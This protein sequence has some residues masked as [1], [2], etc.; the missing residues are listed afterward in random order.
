MLYINSLSTRD[1]AF[2]L[3]PHPSPRRG[4]FIEKAV[5]GEGGKKAR[6]DD[7]PPIFSSHY[8]RVLF[9]LEIPVEA[10]TGN[11]EP[12]LKSPSPASLSYLILV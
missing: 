4:N 3:I 9:I 10:S 12:D 6:G 1:A 2:E 11:T 7:F 8:T 5:G